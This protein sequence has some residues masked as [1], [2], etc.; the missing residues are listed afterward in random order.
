MLLP[1]QRT[2]A[3]GTI[4]QVVLVRGGRSATSC[5]VGVLSDAQ[6]TVGSVTQVEPDAW[7]VVLLPRD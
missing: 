7:R 1:L 4:E 5:A 2:G 3:Y 6:W